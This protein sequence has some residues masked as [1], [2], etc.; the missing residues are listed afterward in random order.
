MEGALNLCPMASDQS[1]NH[2]ARQSMCSWG[3]QALV[4]SSLGR[5]VAFWHPQRVHGATKALG[6][7]IATAG[8]VKR[9]C[10]TTCCQART[11]LYHALDGDKY[12]RAKLMV[13]Q[14]HSAVG[15]LGVRLDT[16][17]SILNNI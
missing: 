17:L 13:R 10:T 6:T 5:P 11:W 16:P 7:F 8:C 12:A 14:Q 3:L 9:T 4:A 2:N 1:F 15:S